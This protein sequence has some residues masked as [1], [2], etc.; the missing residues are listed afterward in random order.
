MS[1][2]RSAPSALRLAQRKIERGAV[3]RRGLCP[4][5]PLV[6]AQNALHDGEADAGT[7]ELLLGVK[8]LERLAQAARVAGVKAATVIPH[9]VNGLAALLATA[10]LDASAGLFA[11][12]FPGVAQKV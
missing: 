4:D 12:E 8:A 7:I 6:V 2:A 3:I 9:K 11:A 10:K 5:P 1:D